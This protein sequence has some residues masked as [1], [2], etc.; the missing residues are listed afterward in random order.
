MVWSALC[1]SHPLRAAP[2]LGG[3][4]ARPEGP[5]L[6]MLG[7]L[8]QCARFHPCEQLLVVG[9]ELPKV[10]HVPFLLLGQPNP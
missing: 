5:A 7:W 9:T 6:S 2:V 4:K 1:P 3:P 10:A 8:T